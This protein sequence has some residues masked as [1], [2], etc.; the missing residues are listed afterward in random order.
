MKRYLVVVEPADTGFS[1]YLPDV[2]GC[3]STGHTREEVE[4][5][6]REAIESHID[7]LRLEGYPVPEPRSESTYIDVA[8]RLVAAI[9]SARVSMHTPYVRKA[10][11]AGLAD[12][13]AGRT[14]PVD[15]VRR[16][17]GLPDYAH[18]ES[19]LPT[20]TNVTVTDESITVEVSDGRTISVPLAWYPRLTHATQ[21][22]RNRWRLVGGGEGIHWTDLDEDIG[23]E[24]LPAGRPSRGSRR[25]LQRWLEHRRDSAS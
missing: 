10:I 18:D 9:E 13:A 5:N 11:K 25:S 14:V 21:E 19:R 20:A 6:I 7:G 22:E 17:F 1:A 15:E 16:R 2:P 24:N 3:V 8:D 12:S 4:A 23:V